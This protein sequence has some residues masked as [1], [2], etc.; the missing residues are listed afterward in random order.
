[1]QSIC[2]QLLRNSVKM[3]KTNNPELLRKQLESTVIQVSETKFQTSKTKIPELLCKKTQHR[4]TI[5][6]VYYR[7]M[8]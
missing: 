7:T 1:M 4:E 3:S 8:K 6:S 2:K 5:R